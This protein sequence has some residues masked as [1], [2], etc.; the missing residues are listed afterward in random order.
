M[1]FFRYKMS[2][3]IGVGLLRLDFFWIRVILF[4]VTM[5]PKQLMSFKEKMDVF[6]DN[7]SAIG[8]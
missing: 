2:F 8:R 7:S 5:R 1:E 6:Y 3:R 4:H